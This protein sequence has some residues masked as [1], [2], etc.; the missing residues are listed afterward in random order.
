MTNKNTKKKKNTKEFASELL[1][2]KPVELAAFSLC[3]IYEQVPVGD[4]ETGIDSNEAYDQLEKHASALQEG[5]MAGVEQMLLCQT[6]VLNHLFSNLIARASS[7]K[8]V[9]QYETYL[10]FALKAQNQTRQSV[11][12]LADLKGVRRTTFIKQQNQAINQQI[13]N[14]ELDSKKNTDTQNKLLEK[15][16]GERLDFG[17]ES[18][19][20]TGNPEME[21]VETIHRTAE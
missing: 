7:A 10:R 6:H 2:G 3:D 17:A 16:N 18:K 8:Y 19:T 4:N 11:A 20:I 5:D 13:N 21:A 14:R 1:V 12:T 9:G 15:T